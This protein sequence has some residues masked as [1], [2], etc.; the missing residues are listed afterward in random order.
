MLPNRKIRID[1]KQQENKYRAH[2]NENKTANFKA[3]KKSTF[4]VIK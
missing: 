4:G 1:G 3:G 2:K